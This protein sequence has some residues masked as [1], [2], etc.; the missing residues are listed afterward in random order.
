MKHKYFSLNHQQQISALVFEVAPRSKEL[1]QKA[2]ISHALPVINN[3]REKIFFSPAF[4]D[5]SPIERL[6]SRIHNES[7]CRL[8]R[9]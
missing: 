5:I 2:T 4:V 6:H 3:L 7:L 1:G 8:V 9:V